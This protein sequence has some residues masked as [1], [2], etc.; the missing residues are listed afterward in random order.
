MMPFTMLPSI[1]NNVLW[2]CVPEITSS[3]AT[4]A[5]DV[6]SNVMKALLEHQISLERNY[7]CRSSTLSRLILPYLE[8]TPLSASCCRS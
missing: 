2:K 6:F 3:M 4:S 5:C 8:K 1:F 7:F